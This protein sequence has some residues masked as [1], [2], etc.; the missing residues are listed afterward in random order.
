MWDGSGEVGVGLV[1]ESIGQSEQ[2]QGMDLRC[3][4]TNGARKGGR[5]A[6]AAETSSSCS[7][8]KREDVEAG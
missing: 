3:H 8:A 2:S 6:K 4:S 5:R 1:N 7:L